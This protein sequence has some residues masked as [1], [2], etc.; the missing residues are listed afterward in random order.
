MMR[1][2]DRS[3]LAFL[4]RYQGHLHFLKIELDFFFAPTKV[5]SRSIRPKDHKLSTTATPLSAIWPDREGPVARRTTSLLQFGSC[6]ITRTVRRNGTQ[7]MVVG[8]VLICSTPFVGVKQNQVLFKTAKL[9]L[10]HGKKRKTRPVP[11]IALFSSNL[12][13]YKRELQLS[14]FP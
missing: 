10:R 5:Q 8:F 12:P 3:Y 11:H 7:L 2:T 6:D 13:S 14:L 1:E 4:T 9:P